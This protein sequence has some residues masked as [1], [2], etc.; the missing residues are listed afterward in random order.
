LIPKSTRGRTVPAKP[1]FFYRVAAAIDTT[2]QFELADET[3]KTLYK[4]SFRTVTNGPG[5]VSVSLAA[6]ANSPAL[7]ADKNYHWYFNNPK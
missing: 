7:E 4:K 6:D 2:V 1:T 5:I 3:D